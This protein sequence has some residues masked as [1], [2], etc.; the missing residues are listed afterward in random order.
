[1]LPITVS[2]SHSASARGTGT[3]VG[4]SARSTRYS[5]STACAEASNAPGGLRRST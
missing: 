2:S 4:A 3:S 5:R 1:M